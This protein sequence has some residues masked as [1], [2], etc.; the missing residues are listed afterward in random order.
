MKIKF[1]LLGL[2]FISI[3][4]KSQHLAAFNDNLN[5]FWAFEAGIFTQLEY[6]EVQNYQI[7]GN[8]I[9]YIDSG[10]N[11]KVYS[12]GETTTLLTGNPIEYTATDYLL[13]YSLYEQLN[14]YDKGESRVLSTQCDGF[15]FQD[16][17]I[18]W[19]N[20]IKKTIQVYH[21]G[22]IYTIEDGLIY[23]P[24]DNFKTG[25]N[26]IAYVQSST[27]EFKVFYLGEIHI[28]EQFTEEMIYEAGRDIVA[29]VNV[30]DQTFKAFYRGEVFEIESFAPK[31][32]KVGDEIM[33][34]VDN[35]GKLKYFANSEVITLSDFEPE[36]YD[37]VDRVIVY[38]EQGLFKTYCNGNIY[39]V[40]RFIPQPYIIDYN[41]ITYLDQSRFVK[42][43][44][45][46]ESSS[47]SHIRV[48]ELLM[49]RDLVIFVEGINKT[50]IYFNGTIYEH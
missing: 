1:I 3:S 32:F 11:L 2:L 9:A 46:C 22:N 28:I 45:N 21:D 19:H 48:N 49:F 31:S 43:F 6:I 20:R 7:G 39:I 41:S 35:L 15:I 4:A 24:V 44:Q 13:G 18:A 50:K 33:A 26:T 36:F 10:D 29:Y 38:E 8:L 5:K 14:V 23:D 25:D 42:V 40:E 16:S 37:I 12:L 47:I 27:E 17:L 34:Y 30:I